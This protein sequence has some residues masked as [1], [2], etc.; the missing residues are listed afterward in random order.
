MAELEQVPREQRRS[1][2]RAM[3]QHSQRLEHAR[4][5]DAVVSRARRADGRVE[6]RRDEQRRSRRRVGRRGRRRRQAHEHVRDV[7]VRERHGVVPEM[8][9]LDALHLKVEAQATRRHGGLVE[10]V[11]GS[12]RVDLALQL[13]HDADNVRDGVL[14]VGGAAGR[15]RPDHLGELREVPMGVALTELESVLGRV[16]ARRRQRRSIEAHQQQG[17]QQRERRQA[18]EQRGRR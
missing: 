13:P 17:R 18:K 1:G 6:V 16:L 4:Y 7:G 5:G 14:V 2:A 15:A 10:V 3:H 11:L 9:A 12:L 8:H